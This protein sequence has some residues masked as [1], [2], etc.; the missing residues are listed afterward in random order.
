MEFK[1]QKPSKI[2]TLCW[3]SGLRIVQLRKLHQQHK[4]DDSANCV[5][6]DV[7]CITTFDIL[8]DLGE[9]KQ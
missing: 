3:C 6:G 1:K 4:H 8:P 2:F 9:L 5:A 7:Y